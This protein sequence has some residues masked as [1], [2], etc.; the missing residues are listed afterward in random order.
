MDDVGLLRCYRR[1]M[2]AILPEDPKSI[3]R[4]EWFTVL[5]IKEVHQRLVHVGVVHTLSQLREE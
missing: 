3:P 2:N 5:L 1:Y 4:Y